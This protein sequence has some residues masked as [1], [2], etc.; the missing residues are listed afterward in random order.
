MGLTG[1]YRL[2]KHK[3]VQYKPSVIR[4]ADL[5]GSTVAIDG[6]ALLYSVMYSSTTVYSDSDTV[7]AN[8]LANGVIKILKIMINHHIQPLF[9]I[10]GTLAIPE[11]GP[12]TQ[13]RKCARDKMLQKAN[14]TQHSITTYEQKENI[15]PS[16]YIEIA[17]LKKQ[18]RSLRLNARYISR[19]CAQQVLTIVQ[20]VLGPNYCRCA[21]S[22]ADFLLMLLSEKGDCAYV[23]TDDADIIVAGA[24]TTLRGLVTLLHGG[25]GYVYCRNK[26]LTHC[27]LRS[28]QLIELGTLLSCDYQPSLHSVG[29]VTALR[30]L[31][32]HG[33]IETF[34]QSKEFT[35]CSKSS[36]KRKYTT[37]NNMNIDAYLAMTK[38]TIQIFT[39]RP[40]AAGND[41]KKIKLVDLTQTE[42]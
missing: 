7:C 38:T 26:I 41:T 29:P 23:A 2:L 40:D 6:D 27:K 9:V 30:I 8:E 16:D 13:K 39:H 17:E 3:T 18:C 35:T 34:L 21:K 5:K 28:Q 31:Q 25:E 37:P 1:F 4:I 20:E 10:S 33:S 24:Q 11:K 32:E 15:T 14:I 36:K 22:E 12:C 42:L 19:S